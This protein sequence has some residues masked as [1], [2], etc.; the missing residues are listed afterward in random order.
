MENRDE[1]EFNPLI[2]PVAMLVIIMAIIFITNAV[3]SSQ[4]ND[5][6]CS[7]GGRWRYQEAVGHRYST[8]YIYKCDNCG[9]VKEFYSPHEEVQK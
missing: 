6:Y 9:K 2:I 7:C 3:N 1:F 4:W 5:G 8:T